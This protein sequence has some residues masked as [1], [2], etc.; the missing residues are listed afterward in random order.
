[1]AEKIYSKPSLREKIGYGFGDMSS[2]MF[3][4]IFSYYLPFFYSNIFGLSLADAGVLLLITK[5]Y[6]AVSDPVMGVIA[7]RTRTKWGRYR[8]YLLWVAIPFALIGVLTF[9]T[10]DKSYTFKLVYAYLSYILMM[11]AYTAINVP[12]GAMLGVITPSSKE[13]TVFSSFRMFFAYAGSFI[14]L[15]IFEPLLKFFKGISVSDPR[16]VA[17]SW[18]Y[19][20]IVIGAICAVLFI[21]CFLMTKER[22]MDTSA[23]SRS[24][25]RSV[26]NDLKSLV[27]NGPWWI[28]LTVA[29]GVLLFNSVRGG[30]AAYYFK[31]VIGLGAIY[32]C[33]I[34]LAVG[35]VSNM[36]GVAL[37]VPVSDFMGKKNTYML[38][39]AITII[40][41]I[42]IGFLP[43]T[44]SGLWF[45]MGLQI[46]ISAA[47]GITFP[48][49]WSMFA[50]I[51]DWSE[52][53][54]GVV[55]T[56]LIFSSS[57]MAQK[58]GAAFG[59]ALILW[60]LAAY[61]YDTSEGAVQSAASINGL[62][63]MMSWIPAVGAAIALIAMRFYPLTE[64]KMAEVSASLAVKRGDGQSA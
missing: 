4:K 9:T 35:E 33:G 49:L 39:L 55:S 24:S 47:A 34:F 36:I 19:S 2:S 38:A 32:T 28:L 63:A 3:W 31:D 56:G 43:Q 51:A 54:T 41:S 7:D 11:T 44:K 53:R 13:K 25:R 62:K 27:S 22:V 8:P 5:L 37:A 61:G 60:V 42:V 52:N 10:P 29:V 26:L 12:Y 18:E 64:K 1:M 48:L 57:S 45:L 59:S 30:V 16:A 20:M 21:L 6:D 17:H 15:V 58:F 14:A 40:F 50:D 23:S 46:L